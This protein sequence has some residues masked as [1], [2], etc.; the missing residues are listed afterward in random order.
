MKSLKVLPAKNHWLVFLLAGGRFAGAVF[1][2]ESVVVHKTFQRYVIRAKQGGSQ[3]SRDAQQHQSAPKS[4]GANLRRYNQM[5]LAND[6]QELLDEWS[7]HIKQ[8]EFIFLRCSSYHRSIFFAGK[9][10]AFSKNDSRMKNIPF[11]T[12]RPSFEE[13]KRVHKKLANIV[14]HGKF[15]D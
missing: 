7:S 10:P 8:A 11:V 4:A 6:I 15:V 3:A 13:V 14:D 2:G 12:H 5:A 9:A 1:D